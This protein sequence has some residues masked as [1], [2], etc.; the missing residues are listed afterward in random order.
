MLVA[1]IVCGAVEAAERGLG[2]LER[3]EGG[4]RKGRKGAFSASKNVEA[5]SAFRQKGGQREAKIDGAHMGGAGHESFSRGLGA[6]LEPS[7]Q[8]NANE[9]ACRERIEMEEALNSAAE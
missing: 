9:A 5:G 3:L 1:Q 2:G 6:G 8:P 4:G 7:S